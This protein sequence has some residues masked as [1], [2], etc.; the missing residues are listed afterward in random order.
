[1]KASRVLSFSETP[2]KALRRPWQTFRD[3]QLWYGITNRGSKRHPLTSKQGNKNFYKGTGS[4]GI[5]KLDKHG[6]YIINWEKVRT[7]VVPGDLHNTELRALVSPNVPQIRQKYT[8]Y[9]DGPKSPE[10][11]WKNIVDF[12][13][14]GEN[15]DFQD[16]EANEYFEE[17]VNPNSMKERDTDK[18]MGESNETV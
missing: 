12:I 11:A 2:Q 1:M 16:L 15:Y 3:G 4:S 13:E 17:Y 14:N 8:G 9:W 6:R 7:Y 18:P 5:G 10:L